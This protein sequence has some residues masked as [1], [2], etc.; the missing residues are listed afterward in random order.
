MQKD[1]N[2]SGLVILNLKLSHYKMCPITDDM[3]VNFVVR[4]NV[5][6]LNRVDLGVAIIQVFD[7]KISSQVVQFT[8][9]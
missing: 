4:K 3:E 8:P 2:Q 9:T 7:C 6:Y 5:C 1:E